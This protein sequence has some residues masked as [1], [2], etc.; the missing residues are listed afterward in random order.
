[1][2]IS[3][4]TIRALFITAALAGLQCITVWAQDPTPQIPGVE[5]PAAERSMPRP[6]T[7]PP[8]KLALPDK[9]RFPVV[10]IQT[11]AVT[12]HFGGD[13]YE[14]SIAVDPRINISLCVT[15][16]DVKI[17][18]WSRNEVRVFVKDGSKIGFNTLQ[19]SRQGDKPVWI[20]VFGSDPAKPM[21]SKECMWGQTIEIDLPTGGSVN[22]EGKETRT[23]VDS[24]RKA[25]VKNVGGNISIRNVS[26]GVNASTYEG[27]VDIENSDGMITL[28]SA[29]GN[30]LAF[31][32]G[33][34][35]VGDIFKAKTNGGAISL[36][37]LGHRQVEVNSISGSILFSGR[38]LTGGI[39]NIGTNNG[40]ISLSVPPDPP[41]SLW[42][43]YGYGN[44]DSQLP[45]KI[46][47]EDDRPESVKTVT[48]TFG[49][50]DCKI[51]LTTSSG[52]IRIRKQ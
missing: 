39:Y 32:S 20:K 33:P 34:S 10:Q 15:Q 44:F 5:G 18:G 22:L 45:L 29:S 37:N 6:T 14:R 4:P 11:P 25:V 42:A 47:T 24:I 51:S 17:N 16:G 13:N 21:A 40:S 35:Q 12:M 31:E 30:I 9:A 26:E 19:T 49:K 38:L 43:T 23:V 41:C 3:L 46:A 52:A 36:Q 27:D 1:M 8:G 28:F 48:G 7:A 50:G 2:K